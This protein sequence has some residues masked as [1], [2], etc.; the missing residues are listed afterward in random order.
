MTLLCHEYMI[1]GSSEVRSTSDDVKNSVEIAVIGSITTDQSTRAGPSSPVLIAVQN[2]HNGDIST[3]CSGCCNCGQC[4]RHTICR[5]GRSKSLSQSQHLHPAD[6]EIPEPSGIAH[7]VVLE[8]VINRR[9]LH[10]NA[11][12]NCG[13]VDCWA[14]LKMR[15][16]RGCPTQAAAAH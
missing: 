1:D 16:G 10:G 3:R 12:L 9:K 7:Q 6:A 15:Y 11:S 4:V 2:N 14:C 5:A 8:D 13:W